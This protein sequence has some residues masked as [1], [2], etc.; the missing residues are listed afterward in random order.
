MAIL[1]D[2]HTPVITARDVILALARQWKLIVIIHGGILL[3]TALI[4]FLEAPQYRAFTRILFTSD[5]AQIST[6]AERPTELVRT[7]QVP[8]SEMSSQVQILRSRDL[9]EE[10]LR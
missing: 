3:M 7:S 9:V 1:V 6:S 2:D 8:E 5:R 10:V 4:A